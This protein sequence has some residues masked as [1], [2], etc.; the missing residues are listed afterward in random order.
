[1]NSRG[2]TET[3]SVLLGVV[4]AERL[5]TPQD[6]IGPILEAVRREHISAKY[7]IPKEGE[8]TWTSSLDLM[9]KIAMK[10]GRLLKGGDPCTHSAALTIIHDFQRG[11]LPHFVV[12]PELKDNETDAVVSKAT[13]PGIKG[14]EQNLDKIEKESVKK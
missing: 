2:D 14:I 7:G 1:M 9:E 10:A 4:R 6:F 5:E 11:R 12:P 8:G 3:D 13:L